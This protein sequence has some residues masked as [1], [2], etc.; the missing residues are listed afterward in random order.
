MAIQPEMILNAPFCY[1][2]YNFL[3]IPAQQVNCF[4]TDIRVN[5]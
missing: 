3:A 2:A 5:I 1:Q 4:R